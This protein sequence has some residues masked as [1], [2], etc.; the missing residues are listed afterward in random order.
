MSVLFIDRPRPAALMSFPRRRVIIGETPGVMMLLAIGSV[1][2]H[3]VQWARSDPFRAFD[4]HVLSGVGL[5]APESGG[6]RIEF[7]TQ[8]ERIT[9]GASGSFG[10]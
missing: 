5:R 10:C 9:R 4:Q 6:R 7:P 2:L 3:R 1:V 8:E